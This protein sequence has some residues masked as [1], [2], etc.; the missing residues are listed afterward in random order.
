[1]A[2]DFQIFTS[3]RYDPSLLKVPELGFNNVGWNQNPSPF[4][5]LDFHR[6]RM[7]RAAVYWDWNAA[8]ATLS[9]EKGI[10]NL[11]SFLKTNAAGLGSGPHRV[12]ITLA[13]D[14]T[15]GYQTSP[16][17]ET[18][19]NNLHPES[20]PSP[21]S[22]D[23]D[24]VGK[25]KVVVQDPL[26]DILLDSQK[27]AKSEFTHYKT[28]FRDIYNSARKRAQINPGEKKEVLLVNEDGQVMEG[29]ISTPYFWRDGKWVTPPIPSEY[30]A[31]QGSGG[32]DGT[33]RRWALERNLAIEQVVLVDSLLDGENCW[34]SNGLRGF[35]SGKVKLR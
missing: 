22:D 4:Y 26:Y 8:I 31:S 3:I 10:E 20:L 14:G 2:N 6:D 12:M 29:S 18:H 28:T 21:N 35:I 33:T 15:L 25:G 30:D 24:S 19:I 1:M 13:S 5:M 9:G 32:N 27:T 11:Q 16:L 7:L 23:L 34:I 17:P